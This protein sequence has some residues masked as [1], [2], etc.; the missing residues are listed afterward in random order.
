MN[1]NTNK[2]YEN[3][4]LNELN[5]EAS[6]ETQNDSLLISLDESLLKEYYKNLKY[7]VDHELIHLMLSFML[8]F[9]NQGSILIFLPNNESINECYD[10]IS[11][12][13]LLLDKNG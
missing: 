7:L 10:T 2:T 4:L 3:L 5:T 1:S 12:N 8:K 9:S 13:N 6:K 11:K